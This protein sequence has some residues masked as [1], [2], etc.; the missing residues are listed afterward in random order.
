MDTWKFIALDTVKIP[1]DTTFWQRIS[2]HEVSQHE[3]Y[4]VKCL[5]GIESVFDR[6]A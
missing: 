6:F 5:I 2:T 3:D 1:D 4:A